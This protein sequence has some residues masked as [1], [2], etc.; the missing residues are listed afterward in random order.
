M[1]ADSLF[2][3]ERSA[4]LLTLPFFLIQ[5]Q[6]TPNRTAMR[7]MITRTIMPVNKHSS[8]ISHMFTRRVLV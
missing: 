2:W 7:M 1:N 5:K 8:Y 3:S 6:T 4:P